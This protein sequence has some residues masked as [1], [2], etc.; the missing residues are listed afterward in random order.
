M[1]NMWWRITT[2]TC[3]CQGLG[4]SLSM[5]FSTVLSSCPV[6]SNATRASAHIAFTLF[7]KIAACHSEKLAP[8]FSTTPSQMWIDNIKSCPCMVLVLG[9]IPFCLKC[10]AYNQTV[11]IRLRVLV[12]SIFTYHLSFF[13]VVT[14][15][16]V[17]PFI[18]WDQHLIQLQNSEKGYFYCKPS[19]NLLTVLSGSFV[20][21]PIG[22]LYIH[23]IYKN[24]RNNRY[25]K[26]L[27]M[28]HSRMRVIH[29]VMNSVSYG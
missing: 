12:S 7:S 24:S 9:V 5:T 13:Q 28:H 18:I 21:P 16:L 6:A 23:S 8:C 2:D 17:L 14:S 10:Y 29:L 22:R 27:R 26:T 4:S 19:G 20:Y 11:W 1:T 3:V 15:N 25:S